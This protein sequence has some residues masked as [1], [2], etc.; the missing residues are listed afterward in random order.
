MLPP[1]RMVHPDAS[2]G[3]WPLDA[4]EPDLPT[5]LEP[6]SVTDIPAPEGPDAEMARDRLGEPSQARKKRRFFFDPK[7]GWFRKLERD[8]SHFL[9]REVYHRIPLISL[10]VCSETRFRRL[11]TKLR[12][13]QKRYE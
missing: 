3:I 6:G 2:A 4:L 5:E 1:P 7:S 13:G 11:M 9:C 10:I 8:T 12:A